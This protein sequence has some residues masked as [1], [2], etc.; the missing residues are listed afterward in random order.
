MMMLVVPSGFGGVEE[1]R[2]KASIAIYA[3][4]RRMFRSHNIYQIIIIM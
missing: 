3:G 2:H 4:D 1:R